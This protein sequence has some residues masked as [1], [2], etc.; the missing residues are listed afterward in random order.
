[1][2]HLYPYLCKCLKVQTP[3]VQQLHYSSEQKQ[4]HH[5]VPLP[6]KPPS[7]MI[8]HFPMA[9][10]LQ[11]LDQRTQFESIS[12]IVFTTRNHQIFHCIF[13]L[14]NYSRKFTT[15]FPLLIYFLLFFHYFTY[16]GKFPTTFPLNLIFL[17]VSLLHNILLIF[18][19]TPQTPTKT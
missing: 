2:V 6:S 9:T 18:F 19:P 11:S 14:K 17:K 5:K 16:S 1:M 10:H 12:I 4:F 13:P 7:Q 15:V 3:K 8:H